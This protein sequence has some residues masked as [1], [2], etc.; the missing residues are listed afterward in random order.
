MAIRKICPEC[1]QQYGTRPAVSRKDRKTEFIMPAGV[2]IRPLMM[3]FVLH[4]NRR[5]RFSDL[6]GR[7]ETTR[8]ICS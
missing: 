7:G 6:T 3:R 2:R 8:Q 5:H 1:G 4:Q